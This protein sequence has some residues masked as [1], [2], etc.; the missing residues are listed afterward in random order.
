[1]KTTLKKYVFLACAIALCIALLTLLNYTG[2][3]TKSA[4][5]RVIIPED[6]KTVQPGTTIEATLIIF[7]VEVSEKIPF[8]YSIKKIGSEELTSK[9]EVLT[10]EQEAVFPLTFPLPKN[11]ESGIYQLKISRE[12]NGA[13]TAELF[14]VRKDPQEFWAKI[15]RIFIYILTL[16][17]LLA[18]I[19]V[20]KRY[21]EWLRNIRM[22]LIQLS[23]NIKWSARRKNYFLKHL[24]II[25]AILII[26]ILSIILFL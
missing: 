11:A 9:K 18:I 20:V 14:E 2:N 13:S 16:A 19:I 25:I 26:I 17:I 1:M 15:L 5:F 7:N 24:S 12:D 6:F 23:L 22:N 21:W 8:I 4:E 10:V 3:A